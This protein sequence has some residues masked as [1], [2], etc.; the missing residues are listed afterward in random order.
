[1]SFNS[2]AAK[3]RPGQTCLPWPK[4]MWTGLDV[5]IPTF[6]ADPSLIFENRSPSNFK[7]YS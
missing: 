3:Y 1:M 2:H 6:F 4:G 7:G 5:T